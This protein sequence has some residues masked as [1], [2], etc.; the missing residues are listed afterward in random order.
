MPNLGF[1]LYFKLFL[2]VTG[3]NLKVRTI[4]DMPLLVNIK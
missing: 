3:G 2:R 1:N 4:K